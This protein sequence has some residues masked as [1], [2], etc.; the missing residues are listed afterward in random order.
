VINVPRFIELFLFP[1]GSIIVLGLF[2]LLL[3]KKWPSTG[4]F[5]VLLA[6]VL[7]WL[8]STPWLSFKLLDGLQNQYSAIGAQT[9]QADSII[10]LGGGVTMLD[11]KGLLSPGSFERI[12]YAARMAEKT[13]LPLILTGGSTFTDGKTEAEV[14]AQV[15]RDDFALKPVIIDEQSQTTW[16]HPKYLKPALENHGFSSPVIVTHYWHMPRSMY[17]FHKQGIQALAAPVQRVVPQGIEKG[18]WAFLPRARALENT[19]IAL[20]EWLGLWV[21]KQRN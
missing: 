5:F 18:F 1:P 3:R 6:F 12:Y 4:N 17:S 20:H 19:R 8:F 11:G 15:L 14:A 2:G 21:Y 13:G 7:L 9:F 16:E 10:V